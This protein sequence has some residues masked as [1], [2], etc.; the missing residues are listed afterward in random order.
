V[1]A[2]D[3]DGKTAFMY[4]VMKGNYL[5]VDVKGGTAAVYDTV[6][7]RHFLFQ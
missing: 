7:E 6:R 3:H 5:D 4:L 2:I 1:N